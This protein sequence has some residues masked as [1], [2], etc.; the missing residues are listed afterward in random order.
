MSVGT[1]ITFDLLVAVLTAATWLGAGA[2]AAARRSGIALALFVAAAVLSVA[3]AATAAV[4]AGAGWWFV[5]EKVTLT[6]P[7]LAVAGGVAAAVA[8]PRLVRAARGGRADLAGR[9]AVVVPLL[10]AGYAAVAG[11]VYALLL[12]YPA[13]WS[14]GLV[15]V[16]LVGAAVLLTWRI[17][18][19]P[20]SYQGKEFKDKENLGIAPVPAGSV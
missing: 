10:S 13:T 11:P 15:T 12:G 14:A 2:A 3:R 6:L 20:R 9:P 7:L 4:L 17:V 5:Q 19:A 1:L 18:S 16:A 8:G